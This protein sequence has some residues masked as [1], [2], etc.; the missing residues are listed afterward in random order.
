MLLEPLT[1]DIARL[2]AVVTF[3]CRPRGPHIWQPDL[4]DHALDAGIL[5]SL[6]Q[7]LCLGTQKAIRSC[8]D[9]CCNRA[10]CAVTPYALRASL[11]DA[12]TVRC[13]VDQMISVSLVTSFVCRE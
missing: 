10:K 13:K 12:G 8:W 9:H 4:Q 7:A 3:K 11:E 2:V 5:A 6:S 1:H